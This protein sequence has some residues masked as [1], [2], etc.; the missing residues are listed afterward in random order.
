MKSKLLTFTIIVCA[1]LSIF[2]IPVFAADD[3]H[4]VDISRPEGDEVVTKQVFSIFGTCIYDETTISF[5]YYDNEAGDYKPLKTTDGVSTFKVG[6]GKMFGKDIRLKKGP[7]DIKI[8][9][10]TKETKNSPEEFYYTITFGEAKKSGD[11]FEKAID[12]ITNPGG[13]KDKKD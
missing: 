6:N 4:V 13:E 10:Y 8:T 5:E 7:N 11:W 2:F 12:W 3:N 9:A 1:M